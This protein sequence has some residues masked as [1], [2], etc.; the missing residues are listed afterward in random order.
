MK[1]WIYR[2]A[3]VIGPRSN[4][5]IIYDLIEKLKKNPNRLEILGDGEQNKSYVYISDCIDA[6][7]TGLKGND[8]VN[9]YNIGSEDS[10]K[11]KKI[12]RYVCDF[13]ELDPVFEF[14]G[15]KTG[16]KG[17]IPKMQLDI[18]KIKSLG[19]TPKMNSEEAVKRTIKEMVEK[20]GN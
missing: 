11:V 3:N 5:G 2:L 13:M 19:W 12:A 17:D 6:F 4:H 9:I 20:N 15:G 14:T 8:K 16:W 18:K 10:T 7:F 1:A